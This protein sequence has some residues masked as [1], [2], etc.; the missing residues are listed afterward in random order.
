MGV[1]AQTQGPGLE[2]TV[3]EALR[4]F[5]AYHSRPR[6]PEELIAA[7][8]LQD[9]ATTRIPKLSGGQRRRLDVAIGVQGRPELLFLDEPTTGMDPGA[10]RQ[11]W[12]LIESLRADGTTVVLTTHYLDEAAHLADRVGVMADG[13]LVDLAPPDRLGAG[14]QLD[15]TVSWSENGAVRRIATPTPTD[16]VRDLLARHPGAEIPEL[17]VY[18]PGLEDVYLSLIDSASPPARAVTTSVASVPT[19]S[20]Q[21]ESR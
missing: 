10:R 8:G 13:R 7:V 15:T 21:G 20:T 11:F 14:L 5:A 17:T 1:V 3:R 16:V 9:K 19:V 12:T 4:H 2:L 18:R 6:D